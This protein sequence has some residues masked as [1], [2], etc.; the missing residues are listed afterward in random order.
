[1]QVGVSVK[2]KHTNTLK[3]RILFALIFIMILQCIVFSCCILLTGTVQALDESAN[4]VF[5]NAVKTNAKPLEEK[6]VGWTQLDKYEETIN[7]IVENLA[8][9]NN[10]TV[11]QY[12]KKESARKEILEHSSEE[13][14]KYLRNLNSTGCYIIL[15]DENVNTLKNALILRDLDPE[16]DSEKNHDI[17]VE[18]G[19]SNLMFN[20]GLTLDS[21]WTEKL[22]ITQDSDFYLKPFN[23]GNQY[24]NIEAKDL[25]YYS[26]PYRLHKNDIEV[27]TYTIPLLDEN[28]NSYGVIGI[29][30]TL[31]YLQR[32]VDNM[33]VGIEEGSNYYIG[34]TEDGVHYQTVLI[35]NGRYQTIL[36]GLGVLNLKSDGQFYLVEN[37][38]QKLK[39]SLYNC[40]LYSTN[41]PFEKEQWVIAGFVENS[42]L[43]VASEELLLKLKISIATSLLISILGAIYLSTSINKPIKVLLAGIENSSKS[44]VKLPRT[45]IKEID[46]LALEVEKRAKEVYE[47]GSK[48]ADIISVADIDLG[49][50]EYVDQSPEIYCTEKIMTMFDLSISGWYD[51]Y[52]PVDENKYLI[53]KIFAKLILEKDEKN[54]YRYQKNK[55]NYWVSV[56]KIITEE[57]Q[58]YIFLDVT[59]TIRE[60]IKIAH[61]RDYDVLTNLYNRRAFA[62]NVREVLK[63]N[64]CRN[65]VLAIWDLDHLKYINDS[66]GHDVGD[67]YI[68]QLARVLSLVP[69]KNYIC[70]RMAGDEFMTCFYNDELEN[71][72]Q[73]TAD[74]H[75]SLQNERVFLP[76]GKELP[77]SVSAGMSAFKVD[78][79][80]Y[81]QLIEYADFAMYQVKKSDKGKIQIFDKEKYLKNYLLVYGLGE[82]NRIIEERAVKYAFQPIVDIRTKKTFA[83]EALMRPQS[84]VLKSPADM[85]ELAQ[86]HSRLSDI[87]RISYFCALKQFFEKEKDYNIKLFINSIPNQCLSEEEFAY[88]EKEYGDRLSNVVV[89]VIEN[90]KVD[91]E[92]ENR[93]Y[94]WCKKNHIVLALDDFGTGYSNTDMLIL[95]KFA[96]VKLDMELVKS[97]HKSASVRNLV[98]SVIE[99]CHRNYQK[100]IAEGIE[101]KEELITIMKMGVDYVQG[102]YF[103]KPSLEELPVDFEAKF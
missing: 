74:L 89:E 83:Y 80:D 98:S 49:I 44:E 51:N 10:K 86:N 62:R 71:L 56:K 47:S 24:Q 60:K 29:E 39:M 42:V 11:S 1:M 68:C 5:E 54:I 48:M 70:A 81:Q 16:N 32:L 6:L 37:T 75:Q 64:D 4:S 96:Y 53:D 9:K 67:K 30:V 99:Y 66:Y 93:K 43:T 20:Q 76:D 103:A 57:R 21:Y 8:S 18:A 69:D 77:L 95:K 2:I 3:N 100:V 59:S 85:L 91:E 84:E 79:L 14:L 40:K 23:A 38:Q 61:D 102:Y 19:S 94:A 15:G 7:Q 35:A 65:V 87:E 101:T 92:K 90:T 26:T 36:Q 27:I 22:E 63:G 31:N 33:S 52:A 25:G 13:V 55:N 82:L 45:N 97:L 46:N 41:T 78:S 72:Y 28:H 58:L 34:V 73:K 12:V 88:L 50:I 17:L